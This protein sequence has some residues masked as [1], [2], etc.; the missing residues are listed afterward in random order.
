MNTQ[1]NNTKRSRL[2]RSIQNGFWGL[3]WVV[4]IT[5]FLWAGTNKGLLDDDATREVTINT[6]TG[7]I[8]ANVLVK[9][10]DFSPR[11]D[12]FYCWYRN[13]KIYSNK[14]GYSG[15]L[16]HGTYEVLNQ[17]ARMI[18]QGAYKMGLKHGQ[19]KYWYDNGRLEK[20]EHW[21]KGHKRGVFTYYAP[22]GS[23][24]STVRYRNN[25]RKKC[26]FSIDEKDEKG[27][28]WPD[29]FKSDTV[30]DEDTLRP[31]EHPAVADPE[32]QDEMLDESEQI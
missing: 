4:C 20:V 19:W 32:T 21:R 15:F 24:D 30:A 12:V 28:Q 14:A 13:E 18:C 10:Q 16:L 29:W 23:V 2:D 27:W 8:V 3:F 11:E 5:P 6:D 31:N 26:L 22:S 7:R 9:K 25:N 1:E 17:D